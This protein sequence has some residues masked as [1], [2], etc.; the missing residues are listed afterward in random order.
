MTAVAAENTPSPAL[1]NVV[2]SPRCHFD[3]EVGPPGKLTV[4]FADLFA[5][6]SGW[7]ES[8]QPDRDGLP[9]L[10][11]GTGDAHAPKLWGTLSDEK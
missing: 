10:V 4:R 5:L 6:A 8:V 3:E 2:R 11:S 7:S 1:W 9:V